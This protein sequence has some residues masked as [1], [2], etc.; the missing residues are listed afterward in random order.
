MRVIDLPLVL[1]AISAPRSHGLIAD[2]PGGQ[3]AATHRRFRPVPGDRERM[4]AGRQR[5]QR[6][7]GLAA[8]E[9]LP[10]E[11]ARHPDGRSVARNAFDEAVLRV[12]RQHRLRLQRGSGR[13]KQRDQIT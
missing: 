6:P 12:D 7:A 13:G 3:S 4:D 1:S 2:T 9:D 8:G 5:G 11:D 10:I